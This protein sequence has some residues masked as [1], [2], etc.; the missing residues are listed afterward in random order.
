MFTVPGGDRHET[1][2]LRFTE[3]DWDKPAEA[4]KVVERRRLSATSC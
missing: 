4:A 2:C 3:I 1:R